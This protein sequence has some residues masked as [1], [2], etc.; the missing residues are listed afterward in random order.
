LFD[1]VVYLDV[2]AE[3]RVPRLLRR[4]LEG[5]RDEAAAHDW[6]HRSD[7]ANARLVEASMARADAVLSA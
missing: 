6:V 4:A 5:G 1:L 7:E 3:R 2:P